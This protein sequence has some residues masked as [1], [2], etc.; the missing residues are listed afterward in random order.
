MLKTV[1]TISHIKK[2]TCNHASYLYQTKY[3]ENKLIL[4]T[5]L[6]N[7][8]FFLRIIIQIEFFFVCLR[9]CEVFQN[10]TEASQGQQQFV[11]QK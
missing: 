11:T 9:F 8:R 1:L 7:I 3:E 5:Q 2:I 10:K 4:Q 6:H